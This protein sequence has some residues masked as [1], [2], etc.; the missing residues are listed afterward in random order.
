MV[1]VG[2]YD[3]KDVFADTP[4]ISIEHVFVA[5]EPLDR[6]LLRSK[7]AY[8]NARQRQLMVTVEPWPKAE[9]WANG[10]AHLFANIVA[11]A[12]DQQTASVCQEISAA[13][14]HPIVRWGHEM[15]E[16]TGRYPWASADAAGYVMA[17]RHFLTQCRQSAPEALFMWS[18]KGRPNL[19]DYYPGDAWVDVVGLSLYGLQ[20]WDR[21]FSGRDRSFG[22]VFGEE[23]ARVACFGKPVVIAELGVA[24]SSAYRRTWL[25]ELLGENRPFPLLESI[26]YFNDKEPSEW[27]N[28]FGAPDWRI[29]PTILA[30]IRP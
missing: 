27:P 25:T 24:G 5:W 13:E 16:P 4:D 2:V 29:A 19:E 18:P 7:I 30:Q 21:Q 3:P 12:F 6:R 26:V 17:Y 22:E 11:G 15:E 9:D 8:A 1:D 14:G 23:Y 10:V 20:N 28:G